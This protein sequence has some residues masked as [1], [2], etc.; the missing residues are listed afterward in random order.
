[1]IKVQRIS[2][3]VKFL[4]HLFPIGY[5]QCSYQFTIVNILQKR[6]LKKLDKRKLYINFI[7]NY[8]TLMNF[9]I[10]ICSFAGLALAAFC[11]S[12]SNNEANAD[13]KSTKVSL[14]APTELDAPPQS[15]SIN[16]QLLDLKTFEVKDKTT[17]K[18]LGWGYDIYIDGKRNI[19]QPIIPGIAGNNSFSSEEK[20][21]TTGTFAINK[22]KQTGGLPT[23]TIKELD[24]LGVTK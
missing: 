20:A 17:G 13:Q 3:K 5:K 22:M 14:A 15:P 4:H 19:H 23:I 10:S 18:L 9:R 11:I 6:K 16:S 2:I 8:S 24:S 12:C 7:K 21:K 1:M